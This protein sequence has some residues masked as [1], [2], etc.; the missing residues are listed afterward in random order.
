VGLA[1]KDVARLSFLRSESNRD[2]V[3]VFDGTCPQSRAA[4]GAMTRFAAMREIEAR[5]EAHL[6]APGDPR[7]R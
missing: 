5:R 4:R 7:I 3:R 6:R 2:T 1:Q